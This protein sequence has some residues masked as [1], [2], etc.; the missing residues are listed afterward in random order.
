[1]RR[2]RRD[3]PAQAEEPPTSALSISVSEAKHL[4]EVLR[5]AGA[6]ISEL[7]R[8]DVDE[9]W[10]AEAS[11]SA[12][13]ASFYARIGLSVTR[14]SDAVPVLTREIGQLEAAVLNLESYEGHE[15]ILCLGY[16]LLQKL[17]SRKDA[18]RALCLVDGVWAIADEKGE[19]ASGTEAP[20]MI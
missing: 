7:T 17:E 15:V 8:G 19:S 18:C 9:G 5:H 11:G 16:E 12:L 4:I 20:S 10:V 13:I 2:S 6:Q 14:G 3:K 1:M